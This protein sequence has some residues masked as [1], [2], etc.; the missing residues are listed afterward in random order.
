[1][2]QR[3]LATQT[4][5]ACSR[6]PPAAH[7]TSG[8][9]FLR[10]SL[11]TTPVSSSSMLGAPTAATPCRFCLCC[12]W[13]R[14]SIS[15]FVPCIPLCVFHVAGRLRVCAVCA[16]DLLNTKSACR[17]RRSRNPPWRWWVHCP[18]LVLGV[19][20][21]AT[22]IL[23]CALVVWVL[24][25]AVGRNVGR[26]VCV[27]GVLAA[28]VARK[29]RPTTLPNKP[30]PPTLTITPRPRFRCA[31]SSARPAACC[32]PCWPWRWAWRRW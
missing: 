5:P 1:M 28:A 31:G 13:F 30:T 11:P 14:I 2:G 8:T 17:S 16:D 25:C 3:P 10:I 22:A 18:M 6:P 26:P 9:T 32:S 12:C 29:P 20:G 23:L 24:L 7:A 4:A 19:L 27:R 15:S 21:V